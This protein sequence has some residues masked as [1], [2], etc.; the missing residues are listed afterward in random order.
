MVRVF[1]TFAL[2]VAL[3]RAFGSHPALGV[4]LVAAALGWALHRYV[5]DVRWAR[6]LLARTVRADLLGGEAGEPAVFPGRATCLWSLT[7]AFR[8]ARLRRVGEA[9]RHLGRISPQDLNGWEGKVYAAV[10]ALLLLHEGRGDRPARALRWARQ[11]LPTGN[12]E[13]DRSL[14]SALLLEAWGSPTRLGEV[15]PSLRQGG[16]PLAP[17][18]L[19]GGLRVRYLQASGGRVG[20]EPGA[21]WARVGPATSPGEVATAAEWSRR[22]GDGAFADALEFAATHRAGPYRLMRRS[23][24]R[25]AA[26]SAMPS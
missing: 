20:A 23:L 18:A 2:T 13:V 17:L 1:V 6:G 26:Q 22:L 24:A 11:A 4:G 3:V 5:R 19:L 8:A 14:A 12:V 15:V 21:L 16:A 10:Q 7:Q 9:W 25:A